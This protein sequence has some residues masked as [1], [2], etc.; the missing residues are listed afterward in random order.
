M[1]RLSSKNQITIPVEALRE[2]G[3]E[4][5]DEVRV[6]AVGQGR[7]EIERVGDILERY[8][9]SMAGVWPTGELDSLRGEWER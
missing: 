7:V 8:A 5:G 1:P 6:R 4:P 2:A 3:F 9:G